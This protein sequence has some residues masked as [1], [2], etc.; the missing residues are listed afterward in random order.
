MVGILNAYDHFTIPAIAPLVWNIVIIVAL[1]ALRPLFHGDDQ[2]YAYAIG[3][4][5]GTVVQFA[6]SSRSLRRIDFHFSSRSTGA[7]RASARA[8]C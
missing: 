8:S 1:V 5:V 4:L 2:L 7:T 3:V 6:M